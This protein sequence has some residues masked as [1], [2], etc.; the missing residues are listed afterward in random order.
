VEG[1]HRRAAW[2]VVLE[3]VATADHPA[4]LS[5]MEGALECWLAYRDDVAAACGL[6]RGVG[7]SAL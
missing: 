3:H 7:Q 6:V 1:D 2:R 4:V 5:S